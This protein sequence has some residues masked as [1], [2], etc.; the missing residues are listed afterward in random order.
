MNCR[1]TTCFLLGLLLVPCRRTSGQTVRQASNEE[2]PYSS[3]IPGRYCGP[4]AP[5]CDA[6]VLAIEERNESKFRSTS[7][8]AEITIQKFKKEGKKGYSPGADNSYQVEVE[9]GWKTKIRKIFAAENWK[10]IWWRFN[11]GGFVDM[12]CLDPYHF[13]KL[14]Y[15]LEFRGEETLLGR[16][17][18]VYHVASKPK[19]KNWH[20]EGTIWVSPSRLTI[21]RFKGA[22]QPMRTVRWLFLV[23][24]FRFSFDSWRK[25][26]SPGTWVPDFTCTGV[27][28]GSSDSIKPAFR[29]GIVYLDKDG[30]RSSAGSG[31]V[32]EMG[33]GGLP[34]WE[35]PHTHDP[36]I[37]HR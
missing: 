34:T 10:P 18:W 23:E 29:G 9:Y 12:A 32:C 21:I 26:T 22:F 24:D 37:T 16:S 11:L 31:K 35:I 3:T 6:Q 30:G 20:F 19:T 1:L 17:Y 4:A 36:G 33:A 15:D 13:D 14:N 8:L 2:V 27:D 25:E 28:A 5:E 7:L